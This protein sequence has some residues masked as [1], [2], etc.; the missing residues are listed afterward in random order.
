MVNFP[1]KV[2]EKVETIEIVNGTEKIRQDGSNNQSTLN[3]IY[4]KS[5]GYGS[6]MP[7]E[8]SSTRILF[9]SIPSSLGFKNIKIGL[10]DTGGIEFQNNVFGVSVLDYIDYNFKPTNYFQGINADKSKSNI[11][12]ISVGNNGPFR[13]Q[14][15]YLNINLPNDTSIQDTGAVRYKWF[16]DYNSGL[17]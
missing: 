8:S 15:V 7:G 4:S 14:F 1:H 10:T 9:L 2:L 11:N 5:T 17:G 16:F 12:N 3:T 6:L 13:S